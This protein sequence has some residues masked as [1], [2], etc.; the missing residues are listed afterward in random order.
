M[1]GIVPEDAQNLPIIRT[2]DEND[3]GPLIPAA[4]RIR[5]H[6]DALQA[7][8][9]GSAEGRKRPMAATVDRMVQ[10]ALTNAQADPRRSLR[11]DPVNQSL[12][13]LRE[14]L[15]DLQLRNTETL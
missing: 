7:E 14:H 13:G 12:R 3:G 1:A 2:A 15:H 4:R 9:V 10:P 11:L 5:R 6:A 8:S